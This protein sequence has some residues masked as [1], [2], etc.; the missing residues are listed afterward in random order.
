MK[1]KGGGKRK[2]KEKYK[3]G[4]DIND[5]K[6]SLGRKGKWVRILSKATDYAPFEGNRI[7]PIHPCE[8]NRIRA[9]RAPGAFP[10]CNATKGRASALIGRR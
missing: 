8:G 6:V 7:R 3:K 5:P 9:C 10:M 1:E 2:R 4:K